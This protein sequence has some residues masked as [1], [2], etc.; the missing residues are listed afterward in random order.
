MG[1]RF[2]LGVDLGRER[3]HTAVALVEVQEEDLGQDRLTYGRLTQDRLMVRHLGRWPLG[4]DYPQVVTKVK[5]L[6]ESA[7]LRGEAI[8]VVMDATGVGAAVVDLM[9]REGPR[10]RLVALTITASGE[11]HETGSG[12]NVSRTELVSGLQVMLQQGRLKVARKTTGWK[13]FR[14][15]MTG[16]RVKH[17]T[18]G[19][20]RYETSAGGHDDLVMATAMAC[21]WAG[22]RM[23]SIWG[24][25]RLL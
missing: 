12:W 18:A 23:P 17:S 25:R 10:G 9:K 21:W 6:T 2:V 8:A 5:R 11:A 7:E 14:E 20:V 19:A 22:R 1:V 3:D 16:L 24:T 4:M 15:E 13:A